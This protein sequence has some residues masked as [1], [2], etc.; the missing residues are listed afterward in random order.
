MWFLVWRYFQDVWIL[1]PRDFTCLCLVSNFLVKRQDETGYFSSRLARAHDA[2]A[3]AQTYCFITHP[4][5]LLWHIKSRVFLDWINKMM[6]FSDNC[7]LRWDF[8]PQDPFFGPFY[9]YCRIRKGVR[10][11]TLFWL[12]NIFSTL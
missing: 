1:K 8:R 7:L 9:Y 2:H 11:P 3:E 6:Y 12:C 10:C 5:W 4:R